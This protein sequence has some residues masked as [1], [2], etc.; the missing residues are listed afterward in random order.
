MY[1]NNNNNNNNLA[2]SSAGKVAERAAEL[3]SA[4]YSGIAASHEFVPIAV[5]TLGPMNSSALKFLS[6]I[7]KKLNV[8]SND[9][10]QGSFL[11]QRL[12]VVV[13]RYNAVAL[14]DS[15]ATESS[16]QA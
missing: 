16:D 9:P 6:D 7:G 11:F 13:Q 8:V 10:R 15:F 14:H 1:N 5:E 3:K 4:K 2:T 12:S